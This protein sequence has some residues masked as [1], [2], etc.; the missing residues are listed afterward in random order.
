MTVE[1]HALDFGRERQAKFYALRVERW[2]GTQR[3][4]VYWYNARVRYWVR[5]EDYLRGY[6]EELVEFRPWGS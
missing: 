5:L 4:E 1:R 6:V 3:L 2:S